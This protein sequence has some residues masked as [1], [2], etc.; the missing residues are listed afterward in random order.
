MSGLTAGDSARSVAWIADYPV[1]WLPDAPEAVRRNTRGHPST[2]QAV[3]LG[4]LE[5]RPEI[6]LHILAL[7]K[8]IQRD[9]TFTRNG[10]TFHVLRAP[11]GWRAPS[12][13]WVD[14]VLLRRALA[15]IRPAVV[16]AWGTERAAGLVASRLGYPYVITLQALLTWYAELV[17]LDHYHRFTSWFEPM[18]L[19][20][21]RW[22]TTEGAFTA[23]YLRQRYPR[24]GVRQIE[25]APAWVFHRIDRHPQRAPLRFLA[26]GTLGYRKGSD[27]LLRALDRLRSELDFR[28]I[29]VSAPHREFLRSIES[30]VSPS[31]WERVEFKPDLTATQVAAE[32]AVATM[33][34]MPTRADTSPNAVKEAVVAGVPVVAS[35]IGG[36]P[37]YVLPERNG[38]LFP[39][40]DLEA[41]V[42]QIRAASRHPL[43]AEGKVDAACLC[44]QREY[45]SP[46][47]MAE[48][49]LEVYGQVAAAPAAPR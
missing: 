15:R 34:L 28:L 32:L 11:G 5:Q 22:A 39:S 38:L 18:S 44:E 2:W 30:V 48:Q 31:L 7:R 17:P 3:L 35:A 46:R 1:E 6:R 36:I 37:D 8:G 47:R 20:R 14:T 29:V 12:F 21:A 13:F 43:F 45:L 26:V 4:E 16:H 42:A 40:E 41:F 27:L 23:R 49:F 9:L 10:V 19:R 25:H 24:L 33:L